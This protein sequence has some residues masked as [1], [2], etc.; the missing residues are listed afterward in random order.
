VIPR[1]ASSTCAPV[2]VLGARSSPSSEALRILAAVI[3]L[4][5]SF[6]K[7][8]A[9]RPIFELLTEPGASLEF[10]TRPAWICALPT[11]LAGRVRA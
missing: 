3:W 5:A 10:S 11:L 7:V 9:L 8:T 1:V 2:T 6:E 4:L